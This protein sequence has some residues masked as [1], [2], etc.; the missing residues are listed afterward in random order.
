MTTNDGGHA[1][2]LIPA[3]RHDFYDVPKTP[4]RS[5]W[6]G[7]ESRLLGTFATGGFTVP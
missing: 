7:P 3:W 1:L 6:D 4:S 2:A 5:F